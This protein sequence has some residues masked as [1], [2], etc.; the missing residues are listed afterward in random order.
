[1]PEDHLEAPEAPIEMEVQDLA[2]KIAVEVAEVVQVE[3]VI[4]DQKVHRNERSPSTEDSNS[5]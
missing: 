5:S 4:E 2:E 3:E 1:M